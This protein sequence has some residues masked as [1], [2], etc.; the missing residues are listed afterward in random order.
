[1]RLAISGAHLVG[2]TTL[3]EALAGQLPEYDLVPEPY[4]LLEDEG[5]AFAA[6]PSLDD[7]E[8]QLERSCRS[9][10][11]GGV[12]VVFDRCPLDLLGYL[13]THRDA[14]AFRLEDWLPRVRESVSTL[15][16]IAFVPIEEPDRIAVPRDQIAWRREV[17]AVLRDIIVD[18][19]YGLEPDVITVQGPHDVRVRTVLARMGA[20]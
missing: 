13:A 14:D 10:L 11:E 2:K 3:A 4:R 19:A 7:F 16:L 12:D 8:L 6:T 18:D 9:I 5:H 17:D 20:R 15:D 1:M